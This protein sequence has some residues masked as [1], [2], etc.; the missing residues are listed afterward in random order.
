MNTDDLAAL[1]AEARAVEGKVI[2]NAEQQASAEP[3]PAAEITTGQLLTAIL[4]PVFKVLA[5]AW[6]VSRDE[7]ALL[8]EAWG[9]VVDKYLPDL[10]LGVELSAVLATALVFGPRW[11]TPPKVQP[12]EKPDAPAG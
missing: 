4:V 11:G 8:G 6:A 9:A 12:K 10:D 7:C 3:P 1:D 5:P 2:T